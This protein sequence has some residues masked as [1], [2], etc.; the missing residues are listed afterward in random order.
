MRIGIVREEPLGVSDLQ[1]R[2]ESLTGKVAR[3]SLFSANG[4]EE[5]V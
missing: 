1:L 4:K 3:L 5:Q 2:R